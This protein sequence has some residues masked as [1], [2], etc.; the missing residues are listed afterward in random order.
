MLTN[1]IVLTLTV[2]DSILVTGLPKSNNFV[3]SLVCFIQVVLFL[4][5]HN[6]DKIKHNNYEYQNVIIAFKTK[7]G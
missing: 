2:F 3:L 4:R 7:K 5:Y 1:D 6:M